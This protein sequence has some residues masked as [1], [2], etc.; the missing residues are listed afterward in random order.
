MITARELPHLSD[1][2]TWDTCDDLGVLRL[3]RSD[4]LDQLPNWVRLAVLAALVLLAC[5]V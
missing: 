2:D 4:H 5:V 1:F 3:W